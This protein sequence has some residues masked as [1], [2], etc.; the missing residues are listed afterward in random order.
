MKWQYSS[1]HPCTNA[2]GH[3]AHTHTH[4]HMAGRPG[5]STRGAGAT[6]GR[7]S[8]F[9]LLVASLHSVALWRRD[10]RYSAV[11]WIRFYSGP[12]HHSDHQAGKGEHRRAQQSKNHINEHPKKE[13]KKKKQM[14]EQMKFNEIKQIR[15]IHRSGFREFGK[16]FP[17][18]RRGEGPR[19]DE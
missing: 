16:R 18:A 11:R 15:N 4:T 5:A 8:C 14:V 13:S 9:L 1:V 10:E 17:P 6:V 3:P 19:S 7:S 12:G 2:T